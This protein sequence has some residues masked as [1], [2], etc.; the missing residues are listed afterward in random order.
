MKGELPGSLAPTQCN[1]FSEVSDVLRQLHE[2]S[3]RCWF[4]MSSTGETLI[5]LFYFRFFR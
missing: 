3:P 2:H 1:E 5:D 4:E